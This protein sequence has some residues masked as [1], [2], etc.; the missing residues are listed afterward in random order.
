[1]KTYSYKP[2]SLCAPISYGI[3][4]RGILLTPGKMLNVHF[5]YYDYYYTGTAGKEL[6]ENKKEKLLVKTVTKVGYS[7]DKKD[8]FDVTFYSLDLNQCYWYRFRSSTGEPVVPRNKY[9]ID[10][11]NTTDIKC[12]FMFVEL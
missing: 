5:K 3:M 12:P 7:I 9:I 6:K 11:A 10:N 8:V 1:M 2:K 4:S